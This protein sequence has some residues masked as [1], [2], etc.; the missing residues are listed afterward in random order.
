MMVELPEFS[1][2][3]LDEATWDEA[4]LAASERRVLYI[5]ISG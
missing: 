3:G 2:T 1:Q 5:H 4:C